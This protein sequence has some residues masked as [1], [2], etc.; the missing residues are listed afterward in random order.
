MEALD[1]HSHRKMRI[2]AHLGGGSGATWA[3][4]PEDLG[5]KSERSDGVFSDRSEATSLKSGGTAWR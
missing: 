3:R 1:E 4:L 5:T 2:P